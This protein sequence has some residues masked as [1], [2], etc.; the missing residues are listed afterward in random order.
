MIEANLVRDLTIEHEGR[1]YHATYFVEH[2]QIHVKTG[3][4]LFRLPL[5][6]TPAPSAVETLLIGLAADAAREASQSS[7]WAEVLTGGSSPQ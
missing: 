1:S 2:G 5:T 3:A 6:E 4:K 7:R